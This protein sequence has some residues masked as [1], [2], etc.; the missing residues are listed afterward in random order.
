MT[1]IATVF[2]VCAFAL[3]FQSLSFADEDS[4]KVKS[5]EH[6][7]LDFNAKWE[8]ERHEVNVPRLTV[9]EVIAAMRHE[10]PLKSKNVQSIAKEILLKRVM[11]DKAKIS[12]ARQHFSQRTMSYVWNIS[13]TIKKERDESTPKLGRGGTPVEKVMIRSRYLASQPRRAGHRLKSLE[14]LLAENARALGE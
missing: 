12:L 11:P 1:R 5:L 9:E 2:L 6:A 8:A 4:A 3:V 13:L 14:E 7:V 10:A